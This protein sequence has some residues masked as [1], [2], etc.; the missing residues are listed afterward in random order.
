VSLFCLSFVFISSPSYYDYLKGIEQKSGQT[1]LKNHVTRISI[2]CK[3]KLCISW[4]FC[5]V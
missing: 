4:C 3:Q 1:V 2:I 5:I